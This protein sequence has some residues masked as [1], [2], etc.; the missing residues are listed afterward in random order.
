MFDLKNAAQQDQ[1][2][3]NNVW[4]KL[5]KKLS[6]I[7][8]R[9]RDKIPYTSINGTHTDHQEKNICWWTNGF[10]GGLMWLMYY[11]TK[12]AV[13]KLSAERNEEILDK[14]FES[15]YGLHHD[16]G[17]MW[18]LT[19]G[20]NY[21]ITGSEDSKKRALYAANQLSSRFNIKGNFIRAWNVDPCVSIIDSMMNIPLLYWSSREVGDPRYKHIAMEHAN[22]IM[23]NH[24][25]P[26]GSVKHICVYDPESG[27]YL[28]HLAGQGYDLNSSW[29]RGQAWALHGFVLSYIHTGK[30]EYLDTAKRVAH[31]FIA[32]V[33]DDYLPKSD[34]R[35]PSEP[36]LY[37]STA[38]ACAACGL[39]EIARNVPDY[40]GQMYYN[41]AI[42]LL[43]ALDEKCCNY[44]LNEDSIVGMG[45]EFWTDDE[46]LIGK[47]ANIPIIYGDYYF[48]E[49]IYKLK[50]Y[51][52]L[53]E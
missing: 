48:A 15:F 9:S 8:E 53:F 47:K 40:E 23:E 37:D 41:A 34:F 5:D 20:V 26:D 33:C 38:S 14:A 16:V 12:K 22:T 24:I 30:Q 50:G 27:E 31:Y 51:E 3:I 17:F 42:K 25:R 46:D 13:Y 32:S 29:S 36:L 35:S 39:L 49:A 4:E 19:A 44:E 11:G 43:K 45:T 21:R 6:N 7:A 1:E 18:H 10:W 2:F 28:E 52:L